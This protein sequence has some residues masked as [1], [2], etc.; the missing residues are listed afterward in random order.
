MWFLSKKYKLFILLGLVAYLGTSCQKD[1][2]APANQSTAFVKYYGH[3][4]DQAASD[5][6]QTQDG[7]YLLV[8]ATNSYIDAAESDVFVVKT[9][10][11][12]NEMWSSS[13]GKIDGEVGTSYMRYDEEGIRIIELPD[14]SAYIV[15]ANR[16]YV[17]YPDGSSLLGVRGQTRIAMYSLDPAT[18]APTSSEGTELRT[19]IGSTHT[20]KVSDMKLDSTGGS[21]KYV[22]TG[23]TTNL[24]T[25][26]PADIDHGAYDK[27]D[28]LTILLEADFSEVWA[29][30]TT[31]YGFNGEDY[32]TSV[33]MLPNA[34]LV[35]GTIE[36]REANSSPSR[37]YS[38]LVAVKMR[39]DNGVPTNPEYF[40]DENYNFEGGHSTYDAENGKITIAA[41]V[42]GGSNTNKGYLVLLQLDESLNAITPNGVDFSCRYY[43]LSNENSASETTPYIAESI[44]FLPDNEGFIVSS[45]YKKT[46]LES[47]I[48]IAK[49]DANLDVVT[50]GWPFSF[51]HEDAAGFLVTQ[52]I[53]GTVLPISESV[54]GTS[55]TKLA[56]YVF[57]GTF[58][59]ATTN[60]MIGLVKLNLDG[61]FQ[62]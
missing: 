15:V 41:G 30:G 37:F 46:Q 54:S 45:T 20:D 33:Q 2:I 12:G 43:N 57:T 17:A 39:K 31:A 29:T 32:G 7:G 14:A 4:A 34:Y 53:G 24:S 42:K 19:G 5:V 8:G 50:G 27:T 21:Y 49:F 55:Q 9:D 11:L 23:Y 13:F 58:G 3:I 10:S 18:G 51:G 22:L 52:D 25:N 62:P 60:K 28:I 36:E 44:A 48:C 16:T 35:C 1:Q 47:T 6:I 40:G 38:R 59:L 61:T 26:K 56:G